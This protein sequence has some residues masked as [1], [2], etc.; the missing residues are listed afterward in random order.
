MQEGHNA[1]INNSALYLRVRF[2]KLYFDFL[3][4]FR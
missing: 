4:T 2:L 1:A 3:F